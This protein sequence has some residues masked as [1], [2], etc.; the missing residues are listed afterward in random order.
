MSTNEKLQLNDGSGGAEA[1][2]YKRL[3]GGLN[4]LVHTR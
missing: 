2:K 3:I 1:N 4:Y